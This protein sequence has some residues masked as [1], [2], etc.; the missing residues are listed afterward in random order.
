MAAA[1]TGTYVVVDTGQVNCYGNRSHIAWPLA[2]HPFYGQDAHYA[3]NTPSYHDNDDGT[4]SDLRTGLMWQKT[5]DFVRR[6]QDEAETHAATLR[7]AGHKDWRL[8]T[9]KELFSIADFRGNMHTGRPYI[10]TTVFDFEYPDTR[11]GWRSMDA[12]YKSATRYAGTT[13][14]GDRSAFGFNFA[15]GRIKSYPTRAAQ[16]VRCVRG[17]AYGRNDFVDNKDGTVTDR[18]TGLTWTKA[19][20][21]RTMN[22]QEA[23]DY[24]ESLSHADHDDWRLPTVKELQSI[25]DYTRA[26]DAVAADARGAAID[27]IFELT[28]IESWFWSSTTHIENNGACYVCFGRAMSAAKWRGQPMNAHGAGAVRSDP[29]AGDPANWPDGRGPQ[30]DEIRIYNYVRCVR[31]GTATSLAEPSPAA[32][33]SMMARHARAHPHPAGPE[34]FIQRFDRDGD[35]TV[36]RSEFEGPPRHF[37]HF[38]RNADG[39]LS[40]DEVPK[41]PPPGSRHGGP[42][43]QTGVHFGIHVDVHPPA[44]HGGRPRRPRGGQPGPPRGH[45]PQQHPDR[46]A[47]RQPH[48]QPEDRQPPPER[49]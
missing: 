1:N 7:L 6:T 5:P 19:D 10:D 31:G 33:Q 37:T 8:P 11:R 29:K 30:A 27:P 38:D 2:G 32:V 39:F 4:V 28:A 48:G 43:T 21:G 22:W 3:G 46:H 17:P 41:G 20:S 16:Y 40:P 47:G 13:M 15:D 49:R 35:G 45:D 18:T 42:G 12:Q 26:P 34:A 24:A 9:I 44:P 25:V 23:L 36:S 14:R